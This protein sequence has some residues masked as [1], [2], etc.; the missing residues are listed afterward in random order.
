MRFLN[1]FVKEC[2][3]VS[4]KINRFTAAVMPPQEKMQLNKDHGRNTT[5][6]GSD[7]NASVL[8]SQR[9]F[10]SLEKIGTGMN[11]SKKT[12]QLA[13]NQSEVRM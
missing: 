5:T 1:K 12:E 11:F 13:E 2:D 7:G 8:V 4:L 10:S 3:D 9:F 6:S